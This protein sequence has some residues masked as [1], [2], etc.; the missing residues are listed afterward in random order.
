[1]AYPK[2]KLGN[3][4]LIDL[5]SDTVSPENLKQGETAHNKQGESIVGTYVPGT[6]EIPTPTI[7]VADSGTI[8]AECGDKS[9]THQLSSADDADFI[10]SNIKNGVTIF[11][12][13]GT[14]DGGGV[15]HAPTISVADN[16]LITAECG[17]ESATH[18]LSSADDADFI[19]SNIKNG[20]TI[21]GQTGT[22]APESPEIPTPTIS[23][24]DSGLITA[25]CGDKSATH[26]L[27][28]ADDADFVSANIK[29]GITVFGL[30]G[31]YDGGGNNI[32]TGTMT[33]DSATALPMITVTG[34]CS[35]V[36]VYP[37]DGQ[38]INTNNVFFLYADAANAGADAYSVG[39]NSVTG[40]TYGESTL[41]AARRTQFNAGSIRLGTPPSL[42]WAV[43][44]YTWLA[45]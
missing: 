16:G 39:G 3:S 24:A 28:S 21:F 34:T 6:P 11:G 22:Y 35:H 12:Q 27:S 7:T 29:N 30:T 14:Y 37:S 45:W 41:S 1:M 15:V 10:A 17:G 44:N 13:T 26:Q 33:L 2:I 43:G 19:A 25:K 23:V 9:A 42:Q 20:V 18:Q 4:V 32:Q 40:N 38:S 5:T 31:T 8:T 36:L